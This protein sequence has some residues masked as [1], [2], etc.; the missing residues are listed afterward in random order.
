MKFRS[1]MG[2]GGNS[3]GNTFIKLGDGGFVEGILK[4]EPVEFEQAFKE[5]D[6]P[7]FRFRLNMIIQENGALT[8]K[9][10][11]GGVSIYNQLAEQVEAGWVLEECYTRNSRTG[12]GLDTE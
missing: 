4:G 8:A 1:G 2:S 9:I 12:V 7:K 5:G 6:K 10:L 11:E 3:G